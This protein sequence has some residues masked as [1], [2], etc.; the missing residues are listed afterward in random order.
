MKLV[1]TDTTI[2]LSQ[3][4]T[5]PIAR[6]D[7][8]PHSWR[9]NTDRVALIPSRR[10]NATQITKN[11]A[12]EL[13]E[14]LHDRDALEEYADRIMRARYWDSIRRDAE[15]ILADLESGDIEDREA[16]IERLDSEADGSWY[17][18]YTRGNFLCL[19]YSDNEGAYVEEIGEAPVQDGDIKWSALAYMAY[20]A[21]LSDRVGASIDLNEPF[22]CKTCDTKHE[23]HDRAM[24][25]CAPDL[26][27]VERY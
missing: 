8:G 17:V 10:K 3:N 27:D 11:D 26:G 13:V 24:S 12:I 19:L 2:R 23:S 22:T 5:A 20:R 25:C 16:L 1:P 7:H 6:I 18:T 21:D 9:G 15:S 4:R 14:A